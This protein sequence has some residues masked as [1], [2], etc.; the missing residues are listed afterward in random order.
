MPISFEPDGDDVV[1]RQT[2]DR[3][4]VYLDIFA[5]REISKSAELTHRFAQAIK[6]KNGTWMFAPLTVAEFARFSDGK[7]ATQADELLRSVLPNIYLSHPEAVE[8]WGEGGF[9]EDVDRPMPAA[10][11]RNMNFFS[12]KFAQTGDTGQ[13]LRGLFAILHEHR[14]KMTGVLD[15]VADR[16]I[17]AINANRKND[18]FRTSAKAARPDGI[19]PRLRIISGA[20]MQEWILDLNS[21]IDRNDAMDFIHAVNSVNY[22]DLIMLDSGWE[23]RVNALHQSIADIG[24]PMTVAQCF[25]LRKDGIE[26]FLTALENWPP[27]S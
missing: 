9:E 20:L 19:R 10:D 17:Q 2:F 23:R 11:E 3:P 4:A 22:C 1:W 21:T 25:S 7:H 13:A 18:A 27:T 12:R 14:D 5:I 15:E 8:Q 26:R 6:G 24:T 16:F